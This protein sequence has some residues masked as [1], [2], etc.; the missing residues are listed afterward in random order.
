M[1]DEESYRG[2]LKQF[3]RRQRFYSVRKEGRV[4]IKLTDALPPNT[5]PDL[6]DYARRCLWLGLIAA[7]RCKSKRF[8]LT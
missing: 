4:G 1:M 8:V 6:A 2:L 7:R 5:G 3:R